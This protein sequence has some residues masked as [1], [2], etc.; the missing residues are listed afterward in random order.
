MAIGKRVNVPKVSSTASKGRSLRKPKLGQHFLRDQSAAR[1]IVEALGDVSQRT[2][3]EIGPGTG[4]LSGL[5]VNRARRVIAIEFDNVLAAQ[6][7]MR[8]ATVPNVEI[9]EG[10]ILA[11][12]FDTIFGPKPGTSR[13]GLTYTPDPAAILGNLPY[14][15]TSDILLRLF[16]YRRYFNVLVLMVQREVADRIVAKPGGSD[17]GLLSATAQLYGKVEKL[18]TLPPDAFDPPPK[19]ES[20]VLRMTIA[21]QLQKLR[22]A[23]DQFIAFLKLSFAQKRKTLWNNLKLQYEPKVLKAALEKTGVKANTRA[24]ALP[25]DKSAAL[26]RELSSRDGASAG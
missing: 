3:L 18:F 22:V 15:I 25:L 2:V 8:F 20:S 6:L 4:A 14:Y 12:D 24:E 10:D 23:E 19:V 11:I 26:F 17:Y 16:E 7:R 13:P 5:L 1:R 21:P 9:I